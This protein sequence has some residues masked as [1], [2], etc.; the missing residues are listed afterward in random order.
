MVN[1][2]F[3]NDSI[4]LSYFWI[5]LYQMFHLCFYTYTYVHLKITSKYFENSVLLEKILNTKVSY[6]FFK[7]R[8]CKKYKFLFEKKLNNIN[9]KSNNKSTN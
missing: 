7:I 8:N 2:L 4:F 3:F 1:K 6:F 5:N 9:N